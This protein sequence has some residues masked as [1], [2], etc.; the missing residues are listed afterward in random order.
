M[1]STPGW[2]AAE[3]QVS[4]TPAYREVVEGQEALFKCE[5]TEAEGHS[6]TWLKAEA[7]TDKLANHIHMETNAVSLDRV[8]ATLLI[9]AAK[10]SLY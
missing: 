8:A 4:V 1:S 10:R 5:A 9:K 7:D 6:V 2:A 3:Q